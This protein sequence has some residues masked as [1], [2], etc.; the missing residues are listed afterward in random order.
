MTKAEH[1]LELLIHIP[2]VTHCV[3]YHPKLKY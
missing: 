2:F 1:T 3:F